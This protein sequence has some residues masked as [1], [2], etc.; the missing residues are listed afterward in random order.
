M[1]AFHHI[2]YTLMLSMNPVVILVY[3]PLV[4]QEH[5]KF[6]YERYEGKDDVI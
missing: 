4:H 6:I 5:K 3:W 1:H 2:M